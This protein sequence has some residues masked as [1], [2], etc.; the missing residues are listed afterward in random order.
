MGAFARSTT[1]VGHASQAAKPSHIGIKMLTKLIFERTAV[2][3]PPECRPLITNATSA[4]GRE[5]P[6]PGPL[7]A[8]IASGRGAIGAGTGGEHLSLILA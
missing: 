3:I 5:Q 6:V 7:Q 1:V 4:T 8:H 2:D